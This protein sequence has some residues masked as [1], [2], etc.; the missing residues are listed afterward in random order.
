VSAGESQTHPAGQYICRKGSRLYPLLQRSNMSWSEIH[1]RSAPNAVRLI[2]DTFGS[3]G[4]GSA[5][6][7]SLQTYCPAGARARDGILR[8]R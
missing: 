7:L 1:E 6:W 3:A 2:G 4:A 8:T 5:W